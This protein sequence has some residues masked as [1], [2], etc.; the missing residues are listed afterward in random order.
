MSRYLVFGSDQCIYCHQA[1]DILKQYKHEF[2]ELDVKTESIS[3]EFQKEVEE[4]K[5]LFLKLGSILGVKFTTIPQVFEVDGKSITLIGG[6]EELK[7]QLE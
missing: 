3:L 7:S 1:K 4:N 2:V 6:Y 5:D